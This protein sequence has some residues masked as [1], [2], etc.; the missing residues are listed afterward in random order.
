MLA[1]PD[2]DRVMFHLGPIPVYWYGMAY[3][4][5]ILGGRQYAVWLAQRFVPAITKAQLD[6]F[7]MWALGGVIIGGR[8]GHIL[9]FAPAHYVMN[10]WEIFMTWKG[11][12]AFHG[13]VI[14]VVIAGF[15]YCQKRSIPKL[16]FADIIAAIV[17][18]GLGL[19]RLANFVNA[20]LYG[21][22]TDSPWGMVFPHAGPLPRHPSQLYEAFLEGF[23]LLVILHICWRTPLRDTPGRIMG[24]FLFGYGVVRTLVEFVREPD[25]IYTLAGME[26][27]TGQLLSI[28]LILIG[29]YFMACKRGNHLPPAASRV[30]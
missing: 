17:P 27:T 19:G 6:D 22:V 12:M 2:I 26:L 14:G 30:A 1:F 29:G 10:P 18:L 9:F 4:V 16:Q 5:G 13:G 11:G 21:R 23:A 7:M 20:E 25:G 15:I 8:L 24:I 3:V 28:P